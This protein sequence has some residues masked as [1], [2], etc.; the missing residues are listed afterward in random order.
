[1]F[2]LVASLMVGA[3]CATVWQRERHS[4]C[5]SGD[6][7][8]AEDWVGGRS[9]SY[10]VDRSFAESGFLRVHYF[11]DPV[12]G[13]PFGVRLP[14]DSRPDRFFADY[15]QW[16]DRAIQRLGRPFHVVQCTIPDVDS[17]ER[18]LAVV[19]PSASLLPEDLPSALIASLVHAETPL[20]RPVPNDASGILS[21][22]QF[23]YGSA[24]TIVAVNGN[25][26]YIWLI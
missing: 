11:V 3:I 9:C 15:I 7:A 6:T 1:M 21:V 4:Q 17:H 25:T 12:N 10:A 23:A 18:F 26:A 13:L 20:D 2:G 8:A 14:Q 16:T 5:R 22:W 19:S 24:D